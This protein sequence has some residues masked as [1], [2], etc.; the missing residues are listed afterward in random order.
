MVNFE[1][2]FAVSLVWSLTTNLT[3]LNNDKFSCGKLRLVRL[4]VWRTVDLSSI[5]LLP[6][7]AS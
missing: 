7:P 1:N 3:V 6:L 4:V 2:E 5:L